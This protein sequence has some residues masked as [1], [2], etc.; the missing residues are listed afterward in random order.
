MAAE[1]SRLSCLSDVLFH[2]PQT[3]TPLYMHTC[4]VHEIAS[5]INY[6]IN[7]C[8]AYEVIDIA[9][10]QQLLLLDSQ[11]MSPLCYYVHIC[12][13]ESEWEL[14]KNI[15][16]LLLLCFVIKAA[17]TSFTLHLHSRSIVS[18][19]EWHRFSFFRFLVY[20]KF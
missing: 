9:D 13:V 4:S 15:H 11:Q 17:V 5:A 10:I 2:F 8:V 20:L 16:I 12:F 1:Q 19:K 7:I 14:K 3:H 18:L 6:L